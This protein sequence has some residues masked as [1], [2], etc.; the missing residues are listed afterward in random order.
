MNIRQKLQTIG[1]VVPDL[2]H[3]YRTGK[4]CVMWL[5]GTADDG[6]AMVCLLEVSAEQYESLMAAGLAGANG[7]NFDDPYVEPSDRRQHLHQGAAG[8]R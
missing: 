2:A 8:A 6:S 7:W 3:S 4:G 1:I 5:P